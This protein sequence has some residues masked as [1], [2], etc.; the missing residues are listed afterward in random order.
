[1]RA[2]DIRPSRDFLSPELRAQQDDPS[3]HPAW[4]WVDEGEALWHG[5]G[6][7]SC[8]S[9]HGDIGGMGDVA[10]RYPA[11]AADGVLLKLEGRIERCRTQHQERPA[12]GYESEPLMPERTDW[13]EKAKG[14]LRGETA[15]RGVTY[16]QLA[17]RLAAIGVEENERHLR[18]KVAR[19][20]FTAGFLLQVMAA[21]GAKEVRLD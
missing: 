12:F 11:V 7:R 20:K 16:A 18:N 9:C 5:G 17:E 15:R 6:E 13:E 14:L 3:R 2:T 4:L 21:V 10:A 1:V 8:Q 19:G